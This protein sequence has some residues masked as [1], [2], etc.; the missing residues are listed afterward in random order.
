MGE[1]RGAFL[2]F[3]ATAVGHATVRMHG[4]LFQWS[5]FPCIIHD[6]ARPTERWCM[7]P[8]MTPWIT[9]KPAEGTALQPGYNSPPGY[10]EGPTPNMAP[11]APD[12][13]PTVNGSIP[14]Q[15]PNQ[16]VGEWK[17]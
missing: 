6:A 10:T 9:G 11:Y 3:P 2:P 8:Q 5:V 12:G 14:R 7:E 17:W 15:I 16:R 13:N 4:R 1:W